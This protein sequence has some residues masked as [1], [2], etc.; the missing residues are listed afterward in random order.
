MKQSTIETG[1]II[2]GFALVL[3]ALAGR[4]RKKMESIKGVGATK[5]KRRIWT[6]I[7]KAQEAG[8]DLSDPTGYKGKGE[9]PAEYGVRQTRTLS[10]CQ[11]GR[12]T[13]FQPAA[14]CV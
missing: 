9:N 4:N 14:P 10:I 3:I 11:A 6:E 8:I 13:L 2:T 1:A 7:Q 12:T 5:P